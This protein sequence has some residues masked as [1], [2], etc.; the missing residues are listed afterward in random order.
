MKTA[1]LDLTKEYKTYYTAKTAPEI[2]EF[3]E[4]QFLAIEGKGAPGGEEFTAKVEALYPLA[5][6]IKNISKKQGNDFVVPKLE[7]LWWV[8]SDKPALEVPREE[9]RW[10]L[11]IH[12]PDF[13]TSKIVDKA[14]EEVFKKKGIEIVKEIEFEKITEGKCIQI[15]HIGS[16]STESDTIEK[17]R[18]FMEENNLVENGLH[19]EVYLSD[20]RKAAPEKMKTILR[21]PVRKR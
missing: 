14:K 9:W 8:E 16:Y 1:K 3:G 20:P 12:L 5:Y 15:M 21:Q 11:L 10:K 13:V 2:V 6:G 18:N 17:M 19:H 7:G 4:A